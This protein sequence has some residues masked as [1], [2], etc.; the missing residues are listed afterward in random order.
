MKIENEISTENIKKKL[1]ERMIEQ[2]LIRRNSKYGQF[3]IQTNEVQ[4]YLLCVILKRIILPNK[5]LI[6]CLE[7]QTLGELI[8]NFRICV[9]NSIELSITED[10]KQYNEKRVVLAHKMY[11]AKK[12]TEADCELALKLGNKLLIELRQFI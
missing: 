4:I 5:K 6:E 3:I 7:K 12:L 1:I 10:L 8:H 2:K 9:K 11:T